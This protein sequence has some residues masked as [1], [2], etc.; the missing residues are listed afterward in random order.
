MSIF[1]ANLKDKMKL[2]SL[3]KVY[4]EFVRKRALQR[5]GGCERCLT[6]KRDL[7]KDNGQV[8]PAWKQ[9]QT[10]HFIGRTRHAVRYD[11]DNAVGLCGACHTYF[12]G[13][14]MEFVQWYIEKFGQETVDLLEVRSRQKGVDK[15]AIR[16]F[17]KE[18]L[19]GIK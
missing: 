16:L 18:M 4:S 6:Q 2:D 10:A 17:L 15:E 1:V 19:K 3:D 11:V 12:T 9:L 5:A 8:Y 13:H 7:Q 14:P